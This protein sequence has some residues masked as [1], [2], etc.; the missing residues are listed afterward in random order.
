[1]YVYRSQI[2]LLLALFSIF[3][4]LP[5]RQGA[6]HP[7]LQSLCGALRQQPIGHSKLYTWQRH[8]EALFTLIS[9]R[10]FR[11]SLDIFHF[12]ICRIPF[13]CRDKSSDR[14]DD[15]ACLKFKHF[16]RGESCFVN[17]SFFV[18]SRARFEWKS[19]I[20]R[21]IYTAAAGCVGLPLTSQNVSILQV[22][23]LFCFVL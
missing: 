8:S 22:P 11:D 16:L 23:A 21:T 12:E 19:G 15:D 4:F 3:Y 7:R 18:V 2:L 10:V 20:S 9:R 17:T 14:M 1:M 6:E 13:G 5:R